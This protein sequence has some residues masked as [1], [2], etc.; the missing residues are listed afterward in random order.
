MAA[1]LR[2]E[3]TADSLSSLDQHTFIHR[4]YY[5]LF[6]QCLY[7]HLFQNKMTHIIEESEDTDY[8]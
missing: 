8:I 7:P 2:Q 1:K 4:Q 5:F 3:D 6:G